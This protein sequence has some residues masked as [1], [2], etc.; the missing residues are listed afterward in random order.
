MKSAVEM[1]LFAAPFAVTGVGVAHVPWP[2]YI[3]GG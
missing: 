3:L 1:C 2:S